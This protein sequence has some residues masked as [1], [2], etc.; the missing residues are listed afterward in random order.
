MMACRFGRVGIVVF[1]V[2]LGLT[3][4]QVCGQ[5]NLF[6]ED[7]SSEPEEP[8]FSTIF[9][10]PSNN[11]GW[12][13]PEVSPDNPFIFESNATGQ[14]A[15]SGAVRLGASTVVSAGIY[16]LMVTAFLFTIW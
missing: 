1:C 12:E 8:I 16:A 15:S 3:I 9:E 7:P 13:L 14:T 6:P 2:V 5:V 10:S 11:G 4:G